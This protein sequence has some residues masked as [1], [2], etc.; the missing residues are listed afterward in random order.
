MASSLVAASAT[1]AVPSNAA[2]PLRF[3]PP[4][5]LSDGKGRTEPSVN[6]DSGGRIFVSAIGG[7]PGRVGGSPLTPSQAPGTPVW[8]STDGGRTYSEHTTCSAGPVPT[9]LGGGDS[10]LVLDKRDYLYGTDLWV[11]DDSGWYSTDHGD[12]CVGT[13][14]SHRPVDDRNWLAYSPHDDAIYQIYDGVDGL[15]VSRAD[16]GTPAG[17]AT[18]LFDDF[19][20]EVAPEDAAGA[21]SDNPYVRENV[22]PPGG[23]AANPVNGNVY[24]T[25]SDQHGIAFATSTDEGLQW[26]ISHIPGTS[27][28]GSYSDDLWNFTPIS[29]DKRGVVYVVWSE[30]LHGATSPSAIQQWLGWSSDGGRHWH[31]MLM[32]TRTEAVFPALAVIS[33]GHV[34]VGWVDAN[35]TGNPNGGS[36]QGQHWRLEVADIAHLFTRATI[37]LGTVDPD[38]HENSLF[39]GPQGGD[40]GMGDFFSMAATPQGGLVVA[41]SQGQDGQHGTGETERAMVSVLPQT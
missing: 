6:V 35:Q 23:I 39:V 1:Y 41:Y 22:A 31:R 34:C 37:R 24:A 29:V 32:P 8:R 19:N 20:A 36:F 15:W 14:V 25:W 27:V 10:A 12:T 13:P 21:G 11:G 33:S 40:R 7:V 26:T 38:V 9:N 28:T 30:A 16:L 3:R 18:S 5:A 4:I 17:G 2:Q